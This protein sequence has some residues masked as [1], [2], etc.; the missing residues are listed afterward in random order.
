MWP[1]SQH[2]LMNLEFRIWLYDY[3]ASVKLLSKITDNLCLN[4]ENNTTNARE[5]S[6]SGRIININ[7]SRL[8]AF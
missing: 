1:V 5:E 4:K 8:V 6:N 2:Y 3:L 7:K